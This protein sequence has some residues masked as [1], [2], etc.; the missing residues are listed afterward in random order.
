MEEASDPI[1]SAPP[2]TAELPVKVLSLMLTKPAVFTYTPPPAAP[3]LPSKLL[4][5]MVA[6]ALC[7]TATAPPSRVA[8]LLVKVKE[9][10]V[11]VAESAT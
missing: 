2:D 6:E 8:T 5:L 1:R 7:K 4:P 9:R 11:T 3:V 10:M